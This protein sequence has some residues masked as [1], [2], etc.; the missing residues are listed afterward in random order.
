MRSL[1]S[2]SSGALA[3]LRAAGA[4]LILAA[5]SRSSGALAWLR[6]ARALLILAAPVLVVLAFAVS[7][8][9]D[10]TSEYYEVARFGGFDESGF[11]F[12]SYG[13]P[14]TPGKLLEPT[15]FAV[16]PQEG[17]AAHKETAIY[18]A[19]R[20]SSAESAPGGWRIQKLSSTG[21]VLGT[22]TFTLPGGPR[23]SS[24]IVGLTVDHS[25]GRLYAL[26]MGP[27]G[28][29]DA[30]HGKATA[31]QELLAWSTDPVAGGLIA[32]TAGAGEPPLQ[33][34]PL[35]A[36]TG[37]GTV[38]AVIGSE[39]QLEP[40][41]GTPL[42]DP[43]GIVVDRLGTPGVDDPVAIEASDLSGSTPQTVN[44][45]PEGA[46]E[47]ERN[48]NTIVQQV[49][50]QG[51]AGDLLASWSSASIASE[52]GA[53]T[54]GP[55]GIFGDPGG[56]ISVLLYAGERS[57][58]VVR[59]S[60][61]LSEPQLLD[62]GANAPGEEQ[63]IMG[64][65][66]GSFFA[67]SKESAAPFFSTAP[68]SSLEETRSA[69]AEVA[70]LENG[71]YAADLALPPP[72]SRFLPAPYWRSEEAGVNIGVRLL[73]P[74]P[75]GLIFEPARR[76][77]RQYARRRNV[78]VPHR[79]GGGRAGRRRQGNAVGARQ[80]TYLGSARGSA[81]NGT[82]GAGIEAG[83]GNHRARPG[84]SRRVGS[85][86]PAAVGTVHAGTDLWLG[87]VRRRTA[88]HRIRQRTAHRPGGRGSRF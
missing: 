83:A 55:R 62:G 49:A 24:S 58:D 82:I 39:A 84:G 26:V 23:R 54:G 47:D 48:G 65:D 81:P 73:H 69:G 35:A 70:Q 5:R 76:N 86:V 31:A 79:L 27:V 74:T 32:A 14:L 53:G 16:D 77:D 37:Q 60:P 71:L 4:L 40:R 36:S 72:A 3:W 46:Y 43:Q 38:G 63:A 29:T 59:L 22:T 13:R 6:A 42:Y 20:T 25:A 17:S 66:P 56:S 41:G 61:H 8:S 64:I 33:A 75:E 12:G 88:R 18:V 78:P 11:N 2:R 57:A 19:D 7:V 80:R 68:G 9:A 28:E 67:G 45:N 1:R 85:E 30:Y 34:D 51:S 44:Q 50:T 87:P 21:A 15:G 10:P 52:L